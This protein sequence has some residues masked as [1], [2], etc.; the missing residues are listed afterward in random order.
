M[1]RLYKFHCDICDYEAIVSGENGRNEISGG[2]TILCE[3]C[4]ELYEIEDHGSFT[5]KKRTTYKQPRCPESFSHRSRVWSY[6]GV[7]PRCG[8]SIRKGELVVS[9]D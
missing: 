4:K 8:K 1:V 6:P 5:I 3:D 2:L 7:C 9:W